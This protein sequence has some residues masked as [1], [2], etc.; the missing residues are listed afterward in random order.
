MNLTFLRYRNT[1]LL[2][3][4]LFLLINVTYTYVYGYNTYN[5]QPKFIKITPSDTQTKYTVFLEFPP[6]S[7]PDRKVYTSSQIIEGAIRIEIEAFNLAFPGK[8]KD[9]VYV[10]SS[11]SSLIKVFEIYYEKRSDSSLEVSVTNIEKWPFSFL[12]DGGVEIEYQRNTPSLDAKIEL[13]LNVTYNTSIPSHISG[14]ILYR[15]NNVDVGFYLVEV[16]LQEENT[17]NYWYYVTNIDGYYEFF[18]LS[19]GKKYKVTPYKEGYIFFPPYVS[20]DFDNDIRDLNFRGYS[21]YNYVREHRGKSYSEARNLGIQKAKGI[22][23]DPINTYNGNLINNVTDLRINSVMPL[24]F[25]RTYNSLSTYNGPLGYGWTHNYDIHLQTEEN[26]DISLFLGDGSGFLFK[27]QTDG[28]YQRPAG[29]F[30]ELVS[31]AEFYILMYKDGMKYYF[32]REPLYGFYHR[33]L[34]IEDRNNNFIIL[35]YYDVI[36]FLLKSVKDQFDNTIEFS[37]D[38]KLR[39]STITYKNRQIFY[40]YDDKDNLV[41]IRSPKGY[42]ATYTYDDNHK[43]IVKKDPHCPKGYIIGSFEYDINGRLKK[44]KDALGYETVLTYE[45][46]RTIITHPRGNREIHEYD[47]QGR[48]IK[49]IYDEPNNIFVSYTY[50]DDFNLTSI[51]DANGR[52]TRYYYDNNGNL[53]KTEGPKQGY[54][55]EYTYEPT[56]SNIKTIK[57]G[58]GR[59]TKFYYDDKGN[60]V[61]KEEPNNKLTKYLYNQYGQVVT[62]EDANFNKTI[63]EYD[64]YGNLAG[65]IDAEGNKTFYEYDDF[66]RLIKKVD[67][68]G[69][70][71]SY[72][73]DDEDR[74]VRIIYSD[75]TTTEYEYDTHGN[76][77]SFRDQNGNITKYKYDLNDRLIEVIDAAN[78]ITMYSYDANGNRVSFK[79]ANGNETRYEYDNLN[80]LVRVVDPENK[81]II[82]TYD[83]VGNLVSMIDGRNIQVVYTYD[84]LN[85]LLSDRPVGQP[86]GV[87]YSY[88]LVGNCL[89]MTDSIGVWQ[90][91]YDESNRLV[92]IIDPRG[93]TISYTYDNVGNRTQMVITASFISQPLVWS[94]TYYKNNWLKSVTDPDGQTT[95]YE[96]DKIGNRTKVIYP[97]GVVGEYTYSQ[98]TYQ[99]KSI[100]WRNKYGDILQKFEYLEY[101]KVGNIKKMRDIIGEYEYTYDNL[102]QLTKVVYPKNRGYEEFVYDKV[103]N[104]IQYNTNIEGYTN[105]TYVYNKANEMI[106]D[107]GV[108]CGYDGNG[109]MVYRVPISYSYDYRNRLTSI[110]GVYTALEYRYDGDGRRVYKRGGEEV[111]NYF[112]DGMDVVIETDVNNKIKAVYTHGLELIS[113][114]HYW[115][116]GVRSKFY[117][118]YDHLGNTRAIVDE[119]GNIVNV[120]YYDVFGRCWNNTWDKANGYQFVG[121]YGVFVEIGLAGVGLMYMRNRYYDASTGRFLS[122]DPITMYHTVVYLISKNGNFRVIKGML[123][124]VIPI[125]DGFC[126]T[127]SYVFLHQ[128]VY[129]DNCPIIFIDPYGLEKVFV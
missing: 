113:K 54:T 29:F 7:G 88:D 23:G 106:L 97:N 10:K 25:S 93:V 74:L 34:R 18:N 109:N 17:S 87:S 104:R 127:R 61:I 59:I 115:D 100:I 83:K 19:Y 67:P 60:L 45:Q 41:E 111:V 119:Y 5:S 108:R 81:T 6:A 95:F 24:E 64:R 62:I 123:T 101:D 128:Y 126:F 43:M 78:N 31:T 1:C 30:A 92:Q 89:T 32:D 44:A 37:Y 70:T 56:Y 52:T 35:N 38:Y 85:M 116:T 112:W 80:R 26:G 82:Y 63:Y 65:V 14:Y 110:S 40:Y 107:G 91:Q 114:V 20:I 51:T 118:L 105:K 68:N 98:D 57:D 12:L 71:T 99:L 84:E 121:G 103:G 53:I 33:L 28:S 72:E 15:V 129:C 79:D 48:L 120:Y 90:Y 66:N 102:Y 77:I 27:K 76:M 122:R 125:F 73:Y 16:I 55:I 46:N 86:G 69:N 13:E 21:I 42:I 36:Q 50:D 4:I 39:I 2:K 124:P 94:Y 22:T 11:K 49:I 9:Y 8:F 58:L 47:S 75:N 96:Y 3:Y 117:Y